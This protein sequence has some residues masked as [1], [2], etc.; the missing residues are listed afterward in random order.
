MADWKQYLPSLYFDLKSLA[1]DREPENM[2]QIVKSQDKFKIGRHR[3]RKWLQGQEAHSLTSGARRK[4]NHPRELAVNGIWL[5]WI[6]WIWLIKPR[7]TTTTN[8]LWSPL[9][10]SP[11]ISIV[12]PQR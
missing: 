3:I 9:I 12:S 6:S 1:A 11:A 8:T 7:R 5:S 4:Y 10:F 2:Y